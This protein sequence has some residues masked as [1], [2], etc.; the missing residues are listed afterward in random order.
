[1][2]DIRFRNNA[3]RAIVAVEFGLLCY[4]IF[5]EFQD[6]SEVLHRKDML[7]GERSRVSHVAMPP[8]PEAFFT[9]VVF[10]KRIRFLDGEVWIADQEEVDA[11][12][13]ALEDELWTLSN[14]G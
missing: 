7:P 9:G 14:R 6:E 11:L 8:D 13:V 5:N 3:D 10:V 12:L 1:M 2:H 4:D